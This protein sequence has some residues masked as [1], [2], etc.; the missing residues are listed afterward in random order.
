[1]IVNG[2]PKEKRLSCGADF[3]IIPIV[4]LTISKTPETGNMK[5]APFSNITLTE[6]MPVCIRTAKAIG[7]PIGMIW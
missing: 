2:K 1:M 4:M 3:V 5:S 7:A 6:S